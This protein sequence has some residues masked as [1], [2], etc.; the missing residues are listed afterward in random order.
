MCRDASHEVLDCSLWVVETGSHGSLNFALFE[1]HF[2]DIVDCLFQSGADHC[3]SNHRSG[4]QDLLTKVRY[5]SQN[6]DVPGGP[7]AAAE[8]GAGA[9]AAA[10]AAADWNSVVEGREAAAGSAAVVVVD[11]A[12]AGVV[13]VLESVVIGAAAGAAASTGAAFGT[14]GYDRKSVS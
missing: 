1:A 10:G 5:N 14:F 3:G 11:G 12:A 4:Q 9:A 7:A 13:V 8:A 2:D 6:C